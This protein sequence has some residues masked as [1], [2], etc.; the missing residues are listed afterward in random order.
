MTN[1]SVGTPNSYYH[2]DYANAMW[3]DDKNAATPDVPW[4]NVMKRYAT[5]VRRIDDC[6]GDL[7]GKLKK[8]GIDDNTLVVFTT[9]NGPAD[10]SYLPEDYTPN[11]FNSFGPFD[12]IKRDIW[13]GGV[14]VGALAR[15]PKQVKA[16]QISQT[17]SGFWDWMATFSEAAHIPAPAITDGV[18]L[19]PSLSGK[20]VQKESNVY[21][22][23][24]HTRQTPEY[25][26]FL[27]DHRGRLRW[28]M[29]LLR[30]GNLV[31]VR[32]DI[33]SQS[34]D[35]E[36]YDIVKDP[37]EA[38]NLAKTQPALQ[39]KF[40]DLALQ[41]RRPNETAKRPYDEELVPSVPNVGRFKGVLLKGYDGAFSYVPNLTAMKANL[42][43]AALDIKGTDGKAKA[44]RPQTGAKMIEGYIEAPADGEYTFTLTSQGAAFLRLHRA[45]LIDADFGYKLGSEV[46]AKILLKKGKHLFRLSVADRDKTGMKTDLQWSGPTFGKQTI[47]A[48]AFSRD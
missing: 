3:D 35:F 15:W 26:E 1:A 42:T 43:G 24:F 29:Q 18:S 10:E 7:M 23:Y 14:R 25:D 13:E 22:E 41:S 21:I 39:Q 11:F 28:Q 12:G 20:G 4:P 37:Q 45:Q 2:P 36:I 16:G 44:W 48:S 9:D 30:L 33:Q 5:D 8:L 31:G 17:P 6:L 46:S 34:D 27:P 32:A 47:P 38:N 40:K 19:M